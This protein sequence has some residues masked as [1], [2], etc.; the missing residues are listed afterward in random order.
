MFFHCR[1]LKVSSEM[2]PVSE[3]YLEDHC[4][5]LNSKTN[6]LFSHQVTLPKKTT[7]M[8]AVKARS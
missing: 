6:G 2:S 8:I 1:S 5:S 3:S 7:K 4:S